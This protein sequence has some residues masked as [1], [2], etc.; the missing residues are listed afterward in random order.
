MK[1][2]LR[3]LL[4]AVAFV[5]AMISGYKVWEFEN[6]KFHSQPYLGVTNGTDGDRAM[7]KSAAKVIESLS[8]FETP[9][10]KLIAFRIMPGGGRYIIGTYWVAKSKTADG[11][12]IEFV[13][14]DT[15]VVPFST[16]AV[17]NN[18]S[19]FHSSLVFSESFPKKF[20]SNIPDQVLAIT[21]MRGEK[22]C[23]N[24]VTKQK[25]GIGEDVW[26]EAIGAN[27]N[28]DL[29]FWGFGSHK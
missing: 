20:N 6:R 8:A 24:M 18:R 16:E 17:E 9:S 13:D 19:L 27:V 3:T 23:S 15:V 12:Q 11:L 7:R 5:A 21:L 26:A 1:I 14:G 2:S 22:K 25:T 4:L 29:D 10:P 28:Q